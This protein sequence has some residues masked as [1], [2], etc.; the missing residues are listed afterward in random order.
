MLDPVSDA[1]L[2]VG[3]FTV[4]PGKMAENSE[5]GLNGFILYFPYSNM[6]AKWL[7]NIFGGGGKCKKRQRNVR[8]L[9]D[10]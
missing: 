7:S 8:L 2:S 6:A 5:L 10:L 1:G 9:S 3:C 4:L